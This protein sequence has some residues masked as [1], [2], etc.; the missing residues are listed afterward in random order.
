MRDLGS[1]GQFSVA[2]GVNET[3]AGVGQTDV[4]N[5]ELHAALWPSSLPGHDTATIGAQVTP[6]SVIAGTP[7]TVSGTVQNQGSQAETFQVNVTAGGRRV[8]TVSGT[9]PTGA[10]PACPFAWK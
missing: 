10:S 2:Y 4:G 3:G 5:G 9:L 6:T 7:V 8:G 1:L